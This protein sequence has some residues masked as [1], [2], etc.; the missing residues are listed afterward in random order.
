MRNAHLPAYDFPT[1][2][3]NVTIIEIKELALLIEKLACHNMRG[4]TLT[5][6]LWPEPTPQAATPTQLQTSFI[7]FQS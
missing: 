2:E 5:E 7:E 4:Q 3:R 1:S 6:G